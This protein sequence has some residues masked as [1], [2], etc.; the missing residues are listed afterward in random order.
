MITVKFIKSE[1]LFLTLACLL[2]GYSWSVSNDNPKPSI[3]VSEQERQINFSPIFLR[4]ASIGQE[5]F[6]GSLL[7]IQ[8]LME[9]D[10]EHYKQK[11]LNSWMFLRFDAITTLDPKFYEAYLWGGQYLSIIKDDTLGAQRIYSKGL[12]QFPKDADLNFNSGFNNFFELHDLNAAI[13]NFEKIASDPKALAKYPSLFGLYQKMK[14]KN[15]VPY[16]EIVRIIKQKYD[17]ETNPR[18]KKYFE[19]QLFNI[20][21]TED[22]KC[23]NEQNPSGCST[24]NIYGE[25]YVK[26]ANGTYFSPRPYRPYLPSEHNK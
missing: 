10:L 22:L 23:L 19:H 2:F 3:Q 25:N 14:Y 11:D 5:R 8:T 20:K 9:S 21:T 26:Q 18:V 17:G 4:T 15:G 24:K 1:L 6:I 13:D 16:S 7:W 12:K